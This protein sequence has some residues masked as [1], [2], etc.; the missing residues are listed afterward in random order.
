MPILHGELDGRSYLVG[1]EPVGRPLPDA[2]TIA[3]VLPAARAV[4]TVEAVAAALGVLRAAGVD[5][6]LRAADVWLA[7]SGSQPAARLLPFGAFPGHE[8]PD[9]AAPE[10]LR[11][12]QFDERADVYALA[13]LSSASPVGRRTRA[14]PRRQSRS[15][16]VRWRGRCGSAG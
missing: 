5:V 14:P 7:P 11:G 13:C 1:T 6:Q 8:H 16:R 15:R 4:A 12:K 9:Y 2:L 3:T 10:R